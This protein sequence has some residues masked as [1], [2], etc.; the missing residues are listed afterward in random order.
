MTDKMTDKMTA[1]TGM[2]I[3]AKD[4]EIIDYFF[5]KN[6]DLLLK[7]S[8]DYCRQYQNRQKDYLSLISDIYINTISST[9]R[10][11]KFARLCELSAAT[12]NY[13]Y[14]NLAFYHIIKTIYTHAFSGT[15][16]LD[17]KKRII[18]EYYPEIRDDQAEI[19]DD[20]DSDYK[21]SQDDDNTIYDKLCL[22]DVLNVVDYLAK[23]DNN[24]WKAE[25]WKHY[26]LDKMTISEL[27]EYYKLSRTPIF[28]SIKSFNLQ[29][30][31]RLQEVFENK[32]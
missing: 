1:K 13:I 17:R 27:S 9:K 20:Q 23:M 6:Y 21:Y 5:A 15:N 12:F 22:D 8:K 7:I 10:M 14:N 30:R 26:Y 11:N 24:Y 32:R 2:T 25:L 19:R 3:T 4:K 16:I 18:L 31:E 28:M 29:V